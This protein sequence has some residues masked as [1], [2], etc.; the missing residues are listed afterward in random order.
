[1][2]PDGP[3]SVVVQAVAAAEE[4]RRRALHE[5][6]LPA[7]EALLHERFHYTHSSG[8]C[9]ARDS[10]LENIRT[11]RVRY[12]LAEMANVAVDVFG[13]LAVM[14]G[15]MKLDCKIDDGRTFKL[16]NQ[17]TATWSK[18]DRSWRMVAWASSPLTPVAAQSRE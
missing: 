13:Q 12:G 6:D 2:R 3:D 9:E 7:L 4:R 16:D 1:M 11:G 8:H 15:R 14:R 17:F 18:F 10:Y 5:A